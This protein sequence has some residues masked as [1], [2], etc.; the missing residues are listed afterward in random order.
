MS[1]KQKKTLTRIIVSAV[2]L[3]AVWIIDELF[4]IDLWY[5]R[6]GM[7]LVPY[8]VIGYDVLRKAFFNILHGS[9]FDEN[10]LMTVATIGAVGTGEFREAVAVM[11]FYQIGE[12]FQSVAV[13]KSRKSIAAMMNIRPDHANLERDGNIEEIAPEDA[14]PGSIIVIRPGER[15]PLDGVII[16]G[17]TQTDTSALTGESVPV[18]KTAE[19]LEIGQGAKDVPLADR[20]NMVY[21]GSTVVYGRGNLHPGS[22]DCRRAPCRAASADFREYGGALARMDSQSADVS[23]DF[24][25]LCAGNLCAVELFRR[26]RRGFEMRNPDQG[27]QLYGGAVQGGYRCF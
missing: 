18:T 9:V 19:A 11:L 2:L 25:S 27:R 26:K 10:F 21:M 22:C 23:C 17:A 7:Y 12:L 4:K 14:A 24:L 16:T 6:L 1:R 15:V 5:L 3:I 8:V 13:G 20:R